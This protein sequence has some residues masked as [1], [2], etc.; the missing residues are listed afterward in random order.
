MTE[1]LIAMASSDHHWLSTRAAYACAV[2]AQ[3]D[4]GEITAEQCQDWL[5]DCIRYP[6]L[7]ESADSPELMAQLIAEVEAQGGFTREVA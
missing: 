1:Q 3:R 2:V 4:S 6:S 7:D 5:R